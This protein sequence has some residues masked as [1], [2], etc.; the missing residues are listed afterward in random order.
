MIDRS[1]LKPGLIESLRS[2]AAEAV[3]LL[4]TRGEL[5]AVE[6]DEARERTLRW[7]VLGMIAAVLL[8]A[9][10]I[11]LSLWVAALFW[12]GPRLLALGLLTAA[13]AIAGYVSVRVVRQEISTAPSLF[14][15]TRAELRKDRDALRSRVA[16]PTDEPS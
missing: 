7:C 10:L 14:A 3:S 9:A 8:L 13:Y 15:Q 1:T 4:A 11:T 12:D 5:A 6:L 2:M 16:R